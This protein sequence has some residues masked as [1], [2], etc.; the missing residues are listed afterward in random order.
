MSPVQHPSSSHTNLSTLMSHSHIYTYMCTYMYIIYIYVYTFTAPLLQL[1]FRSS[2]SQLFIIPFLHIAIPRQAR[3]SR[4][5]RSGYC[6]NAVT[7]TNAAGSY[8]HRLSSDH[9]KDALYLGSRAGIGSG[10]KCGIW[11][12]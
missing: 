5:A 3:I 9:I 7:E 6:K 1:H 12:R 10:E 4:K 8:I 11:T 2:S